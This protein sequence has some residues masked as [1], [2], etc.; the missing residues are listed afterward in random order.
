VCSQSTPDAARAL[1]HFNRFYTAQIGVLDRD[2]LGSGRSLSEARVLYELATHEALTAGDLWRGLRL[3]P[4]YLSRMLAGF[5]K[6]GLVERRRSADDGRVSHL[7]LTD[8]G[9]AVFAELDRLSQ[10]AAE[11]LV[12]PLPAAGRSKLVAALSSV[13]ASIADEAPAREIVLRPHRLGDMTWITHRQVLVFA[14]EHGFG[15]GFEALICDIA[16]RFLREFKPGRER[17]F[18]AERGGE[19]VGSV[20][21]VEESAEVARLRMLYVEPFARGQGLGQR[22]VDECVRFAQ[23]TGYARMDLWTNDVLTAARRLYEQAGFK[24]V[25]EERHRRFGPELVGQTWSLDL[26]CGDRP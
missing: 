4:G 25:E 20:L 6:D 3:D 12:A 23:D 2:L 18:I 7:V 26:H 1:R 19:I 21:L 22:L 13:E 5:E 10:K 9:R 16:G 11:A 17:C 14:T 24:L 8:D 15:D